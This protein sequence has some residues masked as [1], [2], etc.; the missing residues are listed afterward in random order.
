MVQWKLGKSLK[1]GGALIWASLVRIPNKS[2]T[3]TPHFI[4][5][6]EKNLDFKKSW[7][8]LGLLFGLAS[9]KNQNKSPTPPT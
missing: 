5:L 4:F 8:G 3:H 6:I 2:P 1:G 9:L 7:W